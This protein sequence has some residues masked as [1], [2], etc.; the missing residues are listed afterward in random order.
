M[1]GPQTAVVTGPPGEEIWTDE[2]GRVKVQFFWDREGELNQKSSC[3][4]R[5]AQGWAGK[6]W[7]AIMLPRIGQEVIVDFLEGDRYGYLWW[8]SPPESALGRALGHRGLEGGGP[9]D[10]RGRVDGRQADRAVGELHH[11]TGHHAGETVNPGDP[12]TDFQ[13]GSDLADIDLAVE[14]LDLLL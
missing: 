12:V 2:H 7:G 11:F 1:Q 4:I 5:V 3:W 14:L 9:V 10:L 6:G 13:D 8:V